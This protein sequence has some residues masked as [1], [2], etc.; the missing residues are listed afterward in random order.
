MRRLEPGDL[1][2]IRY[3]ADSPDDMWILA[4]DSDMR[5]KLQMLDGELAI[6]KDVGPDW[7]DI[8]TSSGQI[9][10]SSTAHLKFLSGLD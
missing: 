5:T 4:W 9:I 2:Q 6:V 3:Q 8:M 7:V 1:T 10:R